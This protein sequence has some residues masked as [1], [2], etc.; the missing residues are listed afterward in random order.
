MPSEH[1]PRKDPKI[2]DEVQCNGVVRRVVHVARPN[3]DNPVIFYT[4]PPS[5]M[6][7]YIFRS[8]WRKWAKD[9]EVIHRAD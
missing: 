1:D 4:V 7:H 5:H 6:K 2:L 8:N 3:S 9:G